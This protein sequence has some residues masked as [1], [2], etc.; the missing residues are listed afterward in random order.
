MNC[1]RSFCPKSS[2]GKAG[3]GLINVE[4]PG[5]EG[6]ASRSAVRAGLSLTVLA[7]LEVEG[8]PFERRLAIDEDEFGPGFAIHPHTLDKL[9]FAFNCAIL[10][11]LRIAAGRL[12]IYSSKPGA[13]GVLGGREVILIGIGF[14]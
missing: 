10:P 11:E 6:F 5:I 4:L 7:P 14:E 3:A 2:H 12:T 13:A 8:S 9:P 1:L